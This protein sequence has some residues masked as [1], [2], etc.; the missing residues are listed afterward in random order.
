MAMTLADDDEAA[1]G[2]KMA[3]IAIRAA[4]ETDI[5]D[6]RRLLA[7]SWRATYARVIG[8]ERV[9]GMI[10][11]A[12]AT[13]TLTAALARTDAVTLVARRSGV[14]VGVVAARSGADATHVDRLYVA[15]QAQGAGVGAALLAALQARLGGRARLTLHVEISN[16]AAL[17]FYEKQGFVE[18]GRGRETVAGAQFEVRALARGGDVSAPVSRPPR[19]PAR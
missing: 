4:C 2:P 18:I 12:L 14:I 16:A 19:N 6:L 9:A 13:P 3:D 1:R 7:A 8:E 17:A 5:P 10:E 11:A 15:A